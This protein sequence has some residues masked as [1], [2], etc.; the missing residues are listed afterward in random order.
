MINEILANLSNETIKILTNF[1]YG[2]CLCESNF[3]I[4]WCNRVFE[5]WFLENK[6]KTIYQV[7]E[8]KTSSENSL[9]INS[10]Q[11]IKLPKLNYLILRPIDG[12]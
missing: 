2:L 4:I 5:E 11:K 6:D 12:S 3:K 8:E 10:I 7:I 9:I 1:G